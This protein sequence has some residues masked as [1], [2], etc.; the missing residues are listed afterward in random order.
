[1]LLK[2]SSASSLSLDNEITYTEGK[3]VCKFRAVADFEDY[4]ICSFR[5]IIA[6]YLHSSGTI[7]KKF[8]SSFTFEVHKDENKYILN[9]FE[10]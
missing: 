5:A 4:F 6:S 10:L 2:F 1:M 3:Y 9:E 8:L 7:T